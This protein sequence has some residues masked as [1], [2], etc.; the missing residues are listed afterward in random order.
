[1]LPP[2]IMK[3]DIP[4]YKVVTIHK[5]ANSV[6]YA[7]NWTETSSRHLNYNDRLF[8]SIRTDL[9]HFNKLNPARAGR[10]RTC[11]STSSRAR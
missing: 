10:S 7:N 1:M 4:D 3:G 8:V 11:T 6:V 9:D 5:E 2:E